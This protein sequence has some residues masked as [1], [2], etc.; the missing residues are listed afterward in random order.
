MA[1]GRR[2]TKREKILI[3]GL[4]A[5]T[6]LVLHLLVVDLQAWWDSLTPFVLLGAVL[7]VVALTY[8]GGIV[9]YLHKDEHSPLK[10]FELGIVAPALLAGLLHGAPERARALQ[11]GQAA[12]TSVFDLF[13]TP[14]YAA[15]REDSK[16]KTFTAPQETIAQQVWRGMSDS[17]VPRLWFVIASYHPTAEAAAMEAER[18]NRTAL[19]FAAEVYA[20][21]GGSRSYSVVIGE[22]LT[23]A[24]AQV[25][26]R[27]AAAVGLVQAQL[28]K[29]SPD[30]K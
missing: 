27:K 14:V 21:Y 5:L 28:W 30:S 11:P 22:H 16:P 18:I 26:R 8:L 20:P 3:G 17:S 4:G 2:Y 19:G 24:E 12:A 23:L 29:L 6:P 1:G 25:L 9:A 15:E 13:V 10:L 7:R